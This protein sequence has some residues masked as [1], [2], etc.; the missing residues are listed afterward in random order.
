MTLADLIRLY[1]ETVVQTGSPPKRLRVTEFSVP[2]SCV[3]V[4][5]PE[6][7]RELR[8]HPEDWRLLCP[9][10]RRAPIEDLRQTFGLPITYD[11]GTAPLDRHC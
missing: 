4:P 8:I 10:L 1:G 11:P 5:L 7:G 9:A 3:D 2:G 6:G